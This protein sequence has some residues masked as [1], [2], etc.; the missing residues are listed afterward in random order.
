[1]STFILFVLLILYF[2]NVSRY[3]N[4]LPNTSW[5]IHNQ[6]FQA[7]ISRDLLRHWMP[8]SWWG[9]QL[10]GIYPDNR[11]R[12]PLLLLWSCEN[13]IPC[14]RKIPLHTLN[15]I[16]FNCLQTT[17]FK[18]TLIKVKL[19]VYLQFFLDQFG[20]FLTIF[21]Q[22]IQ[23]G[24]YSLVYCFLYIFTNFFYLIHTATWLKINN[25]S[26]VHWFF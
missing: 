8:R 4:Y 15:C 21:L 20:N 19:P 24:L 18:T 13:W 14:W 3:V 11:S 9:T 10:A 22:F 17:K 12:S 5:A 16:K 7:L 23:C 25:H 26:K 6:V 2:K 1:M